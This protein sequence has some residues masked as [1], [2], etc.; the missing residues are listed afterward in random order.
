V[1]PD[2]FTK[3]VLIVLACGVVIAMVVQVTKNKSNKTCFCFDTPPYSQGKYGK[4]FGGNKYGDCVSEYAC[5]QKCE[6]KG[7]A[8]GACYDK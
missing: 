5:N 2:P 4:Q 1:S 8:Y 6:S 7:Y 3:I